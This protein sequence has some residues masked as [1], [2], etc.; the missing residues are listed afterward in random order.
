[1]R[2]LTL[3]LVAAGLLLS[4]DQASAQA[5]PGASKPAAAHCR[6]AK[7]KLIKCSAAAQP[8]ETATPAGAQ[9]G[10]KPSLLK[11]LLTKKTEAPPPA[12]SGP[13]AA[14]GPA[15][16]TQPKAK[17]TSSGPK[18]ASASSTSPEGASAKCKDGTYWH[19]A[20][21][22]GSCSHHGGVANYL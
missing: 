11:S 12:A 15:P 5:P 9:Q 16:A 14:Q 20:T 22:A 8:V 10:A 13:A 21:H 18:T 7:G 2:G 4:L 19:S 17:R 1:M 6:D 3:A